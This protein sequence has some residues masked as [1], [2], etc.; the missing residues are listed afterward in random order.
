MMNEDGSQRIPLR[1]GLRNFI[2][3]SSCGNRYLVFDS[4]QGNKTQLMRTD[5]DGSNPMVL[6]EQAINSECSPDGK[7]VLYTDQHKLYRRP[8]EG[9]TPVEVA[10]NTLGIFGAISPDGQWIAYGFQES[11]VPPVPKLAVMPATRGAPTHVYARPIGTN[12][13][14]WSPDGKGLDYLLTRRGAS[15][16]WEQPLAGGPPQPVTNFTSGRIFGFSW[17]RDGKSLLLAK[18]EDS[19]DVVLMSNFH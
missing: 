14:E 2:S 17:S 11:G 3:M 5:V 8:V 12:G 9:G 18:G 7:W 15:N 4:S 13:L 6:S 19:S 16:V 1:P 10:G